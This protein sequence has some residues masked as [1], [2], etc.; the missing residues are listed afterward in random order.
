MNENEEPMMMMTSP[1]QNN[2]G[3]GGSS[4]YLPQTFSA[5]VH[6]LPDTLSTPIN[7]S[8]MR[9][10]SQRHSQNYNLPQS[11]AQG[12]FIQNRNEANIADHYFK[13]HQNYSYQMVRRIL[14]SG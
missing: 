7:P 10:T 4:S 8:F 12:R 5:N 3:Y 13:Y 1:P 11:T 2:I 14:I 6:Y 9:N